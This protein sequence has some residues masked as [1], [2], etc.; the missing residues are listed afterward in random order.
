VSVA[1]NDLM[2]WESQ[3]GKCVMVEP[4]T[5]YWSCAFSRDGSK[6]IT[7]AYANTVV[8]DATSLSGIKRPAA[9]EASESDEKIGNEQ[10]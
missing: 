4:Y 10:V 1:P 7:G 5:S 8:W 3:T 9:I 6:L 2:V